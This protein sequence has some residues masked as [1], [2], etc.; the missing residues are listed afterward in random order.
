MNT[1]TGANTEM[2]K[3]RV[4][5]AADAVG[6]AL[7]LKTVVQTQMNTDGHGFAAYC[8][9]TPPHPQGERLRR[10]LPQCSSVS[11]YGFSVATAVFRLT[12]LAPQR[13]GLILG[14]NAAQAKPVFRHPRAIKT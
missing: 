10:G 1:D 2:L 3:S 5:G 14:R 13:G 11:S 12:E 7:T 4:K 9:A 6:H 8:R